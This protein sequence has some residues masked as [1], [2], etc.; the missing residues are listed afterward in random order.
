MRPCGTIALLA[1]LLAACGSDDDATTGDGGDRADAA[2]M[3]DAP[4]TVDARGT[5]DAPPGTDGDVT[6]DAGASTLSGHR[7]R[8]LATLDPDTCAA[9][10]S[11]DVSQRAVFLTLTHRLFLARTPDGEPVIAH[12]SRLWLVLGGGTDGGDCGGAENNRL[13]LSMDDYLWQH[14]VDTWG[15]ARVIEDGGGST[16]LR[17]R[18]IAGPHDPFDASVESDI[19]LRCTLLIETSESRPPTAQAH[20]FLDGSA[21]PVERGSRISLPAEAR[22]LEIDHDYD[23]V[24][25]SN[26]TCSDF[27]DRYRDGYGDF[28]CEWTPSACEA[29]GA[30]CYRDVAT[31]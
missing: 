11:F 8:L 3:L 10:A 26:P 20:F 9:W 25:R 13:F 7:D 27:E 2:P 1:L 14:M 17:T 30:D 23:C 4:A 24:H 29:V 5:L 19:G 28:E 6:T 16:F 15:G 31:P 12:L 18:D 22:M 21:V